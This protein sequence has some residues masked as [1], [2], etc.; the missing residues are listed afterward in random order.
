MQL[1]VALYV[2]SNNPEDTQDQDIGMNIC[3]F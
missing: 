3:V 2:H 1:L